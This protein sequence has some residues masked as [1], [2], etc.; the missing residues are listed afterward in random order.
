MM[1]GIGDTTTNQSGGSGENYPGGGGASENVQLPSSSFD[2]GKQ[3]A[4]VVPP[5]DRYDD[6][7]N[8][9]PNWLILGGAALVVLMLLSGSG[10]SEE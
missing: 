7:K 5:G 2:F 1:T 3:Y 8:S 9:L 10:S 4:A 6:Q